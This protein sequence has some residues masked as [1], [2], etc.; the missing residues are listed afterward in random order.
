MANKGIGSDHALLSN[1]FSVNSKDTFNM[2]TTPAVL[3]SEIARWNQT[4]QGPLV[5]L[6][7]ALLLQ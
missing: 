4:R 3:D 1:P 7:N 5:C 6:N 2:H